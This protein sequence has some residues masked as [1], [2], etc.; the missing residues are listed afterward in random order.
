MNERN[1][2]ICDS[3]IHYAYGLG[4]NISGRNELAVRV[5]VCTDLN[6]VRRFQEKRQ[7]H[8]LVLGEKVWKEERK[9]I[10]AEQIF[11][12]TSEMGI[13]LEGNENEIY[14]FQSAD[15]ILS[16]IFETYSDKTN[17]N[18][19]KHVRKSKQ[20]V[21]AVYSPIHRIGKT[22]FAI[23]LGNELAKSGKTLYIN[24][25]NYA[26]IG[27]RFRYMEGKT[28][29]DLLYYMKQE[30][31]NMALRLSMMVTQINDLDYVPPIAMSTDL[32][33]I[34]LEEWQNLFAQILQ[35]SIYENVI[36]D[37][38]DGVQ[39]L[40]GILQMCDRIYMPVLE[41]A[42]SSQKI[43]QYDIN[44]Q[45]LKLTDVQQNTYRFTAVDDMEEYARKLVKGEQ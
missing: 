28:L 19:L 21:I 20:K 18:I 45:R 23:A 4:E 35:K 25:E 29:G 27:G 6:K 38:G 32:Q 9:D 26:D 22:A 11:I 13:P 16:E 8:I 1:L 2:V 43:E 24:L 3:E 42:V 40:F 37:L 12:L 41:D 33:E 10:H 31:G 34:K 30:K 17:Q 5:F 36:L 39:G 14:R 7:I 44:L 15:R